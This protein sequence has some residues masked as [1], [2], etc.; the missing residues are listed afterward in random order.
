MHEHPDKGA[1]DDA[2]FDRAKRSVFLPLANIAAEIVVNVR[3]KI[4]KKDGRQFVS[5]ERRMKH[6]AQ[7]I[8]I[9]FMMIERV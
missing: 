2:R 1:H 6:Q 8:R 9:L 7:K 4:F 5:F 3:D